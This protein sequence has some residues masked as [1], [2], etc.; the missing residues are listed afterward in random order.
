MEF[1]EGF[2]YAQIYAPPAHDYISLEPMTAPA[3]ALVTGEGL[4]VARAGSA[5]RAVFRITVG[6]ET[7][8]RRV[9]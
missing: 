9:H 5:Y 4:S 6:A 8:D 2:P 7:E 3:N 1:L